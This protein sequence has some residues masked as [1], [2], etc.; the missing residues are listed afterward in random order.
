MGLKDFFKKAAEEVKET[1]GEAKGSLKKVAASPVGRAFTRSTPVGMAI[2]LATGDK[3]KDVTSRYRQAINPQMMVAEKIVPGIGLAQSLGLG[4]GGNTPISLGGQSSGGS[5]AGGIIGG[6]SQGLGSLG[7]LAGIGGGSMGNKQDSQDS[8]QQSLQDSRRQGIAEG[9]ARGEKLFGMKGDDFGSRVQ[10][11]LA[12]REGDLE[13]TSPVQKR[14]KQARNRQVMM[15]KARGANSAQLQA[16]SRQA[17]S[18]IAMAD[19]QRKQDALSAYQQLLGGLLSGQQQLELGYGQ[20]AVGSNPPPQPR[21]GI[22]SN[23]LEP[24]F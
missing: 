2:G 24:I 1:A 7:G 5:G 18:D 13:G 22:L 9:A 16:I 17:E 11:V 8:Y 3:L 12:Q 23:I 21:R 19:W 15:A 4:S 10:G 20:L 6:V 14:L